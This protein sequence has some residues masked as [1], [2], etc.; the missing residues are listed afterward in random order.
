MAVGESSAF[1]HD[2]SGDTQVIFGHFRRP[3]SAEQVVSFSWTYICISDELGNCGWSDNV[4]VCK[5]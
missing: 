5:A 2:G 4:S 3:I 1:A